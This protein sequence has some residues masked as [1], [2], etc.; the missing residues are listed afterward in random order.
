MRATKSKR[1]AL[2]CVDGDGL[3]RL[4][5][6]PRRDTP[7]DESAGADTGDGKTIGDQSFIG[8]GDGVALNAGLFGENTR[9]RQSLAGLGDAAGDG[10]AQRLIEPILRG[11]SFGDMS[12]REIERQLGFRNWLR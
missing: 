10:M 8:I 2:R 11:R 5:A 1:A 3:R 6:G 4:A 9:R 12:A 7:G